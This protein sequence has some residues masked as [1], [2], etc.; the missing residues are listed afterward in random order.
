MVSYDS[1]YVLIGQA[2]GEAPGIEH[3]C[4]IIFYI[5]LLLYYVVLGLYTHR[6]SLDSLHS[7]YDSYFS[8]TWT[9]MYHG[10]VNRFLFSSG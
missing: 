6:C 8:F 2:E 1:S 7:L 5:L 3:D 4:I 9:C 10:V